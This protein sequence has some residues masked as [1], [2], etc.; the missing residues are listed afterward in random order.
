[1]YVSIY[2]KYFLTPLIY[3]FN[4]QMG[5]GSIPWCCYSPKNQ[6]WHS[7]CSRTKKEK[8]G[9]IP[10]FRDITRVLPGEYAHCQKGDW[11]ELT[12]NIHRTFAKYKQ[13]MY[14]KSSELSNTQSGG[15]KGTGDHTLTK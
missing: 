14:T 11:F 9:F 10:R 15:A 2:I 8:L 6:K 5:K 1:M 13:Y 3:A 4:T 12:H 7:Q